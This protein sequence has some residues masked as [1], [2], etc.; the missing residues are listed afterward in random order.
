MDRRDFLRATG[1]GS[2]TL[3]LPGSISNALANPMDNPWRVY[4]VTT[5]VEILKPVGVTRVWIPLP[6]AADTSYQKSLGNTWDAPGGNARYW[7][8]AKYA[9]GVVAAEWG[10]AARPVLEV[11]SRFATCDRVSDLES[12]L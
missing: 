12:A 3:V 7:Q 4:E 6:L 10:E 8:D 5:R 1:A 2:A 9:A 11:K